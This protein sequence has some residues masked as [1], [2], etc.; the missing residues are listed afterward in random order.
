MSTVTHTFPQPRHFPENRGRRFTK[1]FLGVTHTQT[2]SLKF[3]D[4]RRA[5]RLSRVVN[6]NCRSIIGFFGGVIGSR[7]LP[8]HTTYPRVA[9]LADIWHA[10]TADTRKPL[11]TSTTRH[12]YTSRHYRRSLSAQR[13]SGSRYF[14]IQPPACEPRAILAP[15][16]DVR[17]FFTSIYIDKFIGA[18]FLKNISRRFYVTGKAGIKF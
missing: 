12:L 13:G 11:C 17:V 10:S 5:S 14:E 6:T 1:L 16:R 3:L 18:S 8:R 7:R 15:P 2:Q 9:A 4:S